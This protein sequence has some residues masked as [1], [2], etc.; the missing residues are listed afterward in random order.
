[1]HEI[2]SWSRR[3]SDRSERTPTLAFEGKLSKWLEQAK[4][5]QAFAVALP[6][7][8]GVEAIFCRSPDM[9]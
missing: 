6:T 9:S 8:Q 5:K 4:G 7:G 1:M 3:T 2:Q